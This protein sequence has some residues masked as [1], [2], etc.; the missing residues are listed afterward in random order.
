MLVTAKDAWDRLRGYLNDDVGDAATRD[1]KRAIN[2]ALRTLA[3]DHDWSYYHVP[4][5]T[6]TF[7]ASQ[8][9]GT[10]EYVAST[11]LVTLTGATWPTWVAQYGVI[12][13]GDPQVHAR[14]AKR[15]SGTV[16]EL[17]AVSAPGDDIAALST[18]TVYR[19]KYPLPDDFHKANQLVRANGRLRGTWVAPSQW[20]DYG[21]PYRPGGG[22]PWWYTFLGQPEQYGRHILQVAPFPAAAESVFMVYKRL[23]RRINTWEYKTGTVTA[24]AGENPTV[25][26]TST[27]WTSP[28][29]GAIMRFVANTTGAAPSEIDNPPTDEARIGTYTSATS[30]ALDGTLNNSYS[31]TVY[32]IS[33]P[34]DVEYGTMLNC[35]WYC[36]LKHL[37]NSRELRGKLDAAALYDLELRK[38]QAAELITMERKQMGAHNQKPQGW[39]PP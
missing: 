26:G 27:A 4:D 28:M 8:T 5:L 15:I 7:D 21:S 32:S 10:V 33:D 2:D 11:R 1:I 13:F 20:S 24:T 31:G 18:Y 23:P 6:I 36:C 34:I 38:A 30:V 17:E 14:I 25:T 19:D 22:T 16:V 35:F 9:T 39:F 29:G 12:V 3:T 37:A